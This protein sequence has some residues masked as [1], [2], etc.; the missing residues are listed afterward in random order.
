MVENSS[1]IEPSFADAIGIIAC[2]A[3]LPEAKR[4]HWATSLRQIAKLLDKPLEL[5]PARYSAVRADLL[6]L[7]HAPSGLTA[8]TLQNH[9]SNAKAALLWLAREKGIPEHGAPLSPAWAELRAKIKGGVARSRLSSFMRFSSANNAVP[10]DVDETVVDRFSEYR[11]HCGKPVDDAFRRLLACA[12]NENVG[13]IPGWPSRRLAEPAVKA[14]VD[15]AWEA[16]P[17]GLHRDLDRYL[18]GLSKTRK[19]RHSYAVTFARF[20]R[21]GL[22]AAS[23]AHG[24]PWQQFSVRKASKPFIVSN[25]AVCQIKTPQPYLH[26][27][28]RSESGAVSADL[29]A[30]RKFVDRTVPSSNKK[31]RLAV[32]LP[33]CVT[34]IV[35]VRASQRGSSRLFAVR[36]SR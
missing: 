12:W 31:R 25:R 27:I 14:A 2:A 33:V 3:E 19:T 30:R 6:H 9:K 28:T 18:R 36:L 15:I 17:A 11:L 16:F 24:A 13:I 29:P 8:K 10:T 7:H 21:M 4:R 5:I 26:R 20:A 35:A 23:G 34:P 1:L 22:H 32:H